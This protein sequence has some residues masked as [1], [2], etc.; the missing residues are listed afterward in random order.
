VS[1]ITKI[2]RKAVDKLENVFC[3]CMSEKLVCF[4]CEERTTKVSIRKTEKGQ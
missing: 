4:L 2:K 1:K 3:M